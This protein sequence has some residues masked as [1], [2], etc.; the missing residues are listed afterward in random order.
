M[1]TE[2]GLDLF[3]KK[4]HTR[5]RKERIGFLGNQASVVH[6]LRHA[7]DLILE[8]NLKLNVTCFI[9]P[10]HG[11]RGEKQDNMIESDDFI[12]SKTNIPC[13]SLYGSSRKPS[14]KVLSN[15]DAFIIDL[16]DI[17]CRIYTFMYTMLY[18]MEAA[19]AHGKK[20][21]VLDRPNP[22]GGSQVEGNFLD[23]KFSS[24]VGLFPMSTRH[25]MTMGELALMFNEELNIHCDLEIIKIKGWERKLFS[26][27]WG[28]QWVPPS[29]NIP[30]AEAAHTFPGI[31]HFEGTNV[32]E[33]RGTTMPFLYVGAP[34]INADTL[35]E[36]MN[37][38]KLSGVYFRP[39][40]FQPTFHKGK[41]Q[42]LGGVQIHVLDRVKFNSFEAGLHLLAMIA[43]LYPKLFQWKQPPYEYETEKMPIDLIGGT[44]E[45]RKLI[46]TQS[47]IKNFLEK[48]RED[49]ATFKK[50]RAKYLLY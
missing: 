37:R 40:Y 32:S 25:G 7:S 39:I 50:V 6:D 47:P 26:E 16:Q 24:F 27:S 30:I 28:R 34:F 9:G 12:D 13:Y 31:V 43:Q 21:I 33:G 29:P 23:M 45:I 19:K 46:D 36:K 18:C 8:K 49:V 2:T 11:I 3:L 14:L 35:G 41:D 17:G 38:L 1:K 5:F 15:L 20:V 10:Q 44:D 42:V 48:S 22:I 4:E